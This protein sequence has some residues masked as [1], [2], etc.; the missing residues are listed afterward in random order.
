M[1]TYNKTI[2]VEVSVDSIAQKLASIINPQT[3]GIDGIVESIIG[4]ALQNDGLSYLYNAL[5]GYSNDIVFKP[6]D[7]VIYSGSISM[8]N[9]EGKHGYE[10]T[11]QVMTVIETDPYRS[12]KVLIEYNNLK[13]V[14][15]EWVSHDR[16]TI[17]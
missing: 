11:N 2:T 10:T 14:C 3:P 1:K 9:A 6:G 4:P 8:Y 12:N 7:Q 5:S 15:Q 16:L 17:A 13:S